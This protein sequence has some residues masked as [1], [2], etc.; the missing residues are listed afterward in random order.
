MQTVELK[1]ANPVVREEMLEVPTLTQGATREV[2][3]EYN[4]VKDWVEYS[5]AV[6]DQ[7]HAHVLARISL[8]GTAL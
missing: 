1:S 5:A 6:E 7:S 8:E 4:F 2:S 3:E